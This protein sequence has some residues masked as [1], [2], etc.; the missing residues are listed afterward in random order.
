MSEG[1]IGL[2]PAYGFFN[3]QNIAGTAATTY[4]LDFDVVSANGMIVSLDGIVQEPGYAFSVGRSAAGVMQITFAEA[5]PVTTIS[6]SLAFNAG[7]ALITGFTAAQVSNL[8]IG[9]GVTGNSSIPED[10]FIA[11][12]PST[13]SITITNAVT[14]SE[15]SQSVTFGSRIYVIYLGNVLQTSSSATV[16]T[17]PLV[18]YFSSDGTA[19][20]VSLG[21][22]PPTAGSIAVYL[23][24]VFQRGGSGKAYTLSGGAITFTGATPAGGSSNIT[25]FHLATEDNRVTNTVQAGA[26]TN[27]KLNLDYSNANYRAPTVDASFAATTK[28]I[29]S[30]SGT[31]NYGVNDVLV[32]LN[33]V[34]LTPTTDYTI[35]ATTMTLVG[36]APPA[37]SNLVVRYLPLTG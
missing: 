32:F 26:V 25:V 34:C 13:T 20:S 14:S 30:A 7:T 4:S 29:K 21:R 17:Q 5:L 27:A 15:T 9:Q 8:V 2:A 37:G 35:S 36:G 33:G 12:K 28:S 24:G 11:T 6:S 19:Q 31:V 22:T 3:K 10:T 1:Y 23:D 16:N 18:E